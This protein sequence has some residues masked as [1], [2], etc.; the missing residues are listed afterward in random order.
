MAELGPIADAEHERVGELAARLRGRPLLAIGADAK[1]IVGRGVREGV[2][3]DAA[4][5]RRP[6]AAL[7]DVRRAAAAGRRRARERV[8]RRRAR[9]A[10]RAL[11]EALT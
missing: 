3:P 2:E 8:P 4:R 5:L 10:R 6:D 11:A 1:A 7:A 9:G